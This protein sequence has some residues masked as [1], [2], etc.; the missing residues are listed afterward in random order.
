MSEWK[1]GVAVIML[2]LVFWLMGMAV[3][4]GAFY[5]AEGRWCSV[6]SICGAVQAP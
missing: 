5:N 4:A 2:I 1:M 6:E 3:V